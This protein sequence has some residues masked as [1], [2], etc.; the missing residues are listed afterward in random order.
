[1]TLPN[2]RLLRVGWRAGYDKARAMEKASFVE[3]QALIFV[4]GLTGVGKSSSLEGIQVQRNVTLLPNRRALT[5][6]IIIPAVQVWE[7]KP[8]APVTDRLERFDY[9][10]RYRERHPGGVVHA[11]ERYLAN[12]PL[13]Q[14]NNNHPVLFDNIRGQDETRY[15]VNTFA[16][17]RFIILDAPPLERLKRMTT[18]QDSFDH[19]RATRLENDTFIANLQAIADADRVFDLYEVARLEAAGYD[20]DALL[21]G[22]RIISREQVHYDAQAALSVLEHLPENRLLYLDTSQRS[23]EDV[24]SLLLAWL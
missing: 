14:A 13:S 7:G 1:M 17:S 4:V 23:L 21:T 22:V 12:T 18:R 11:L 6:R 9:T 5:D 16:N 3:N 10:R 15:A 8:A 2:A 24:V 19:V 20:E